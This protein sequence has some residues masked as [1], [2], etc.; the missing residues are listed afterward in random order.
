M[1]K[2][3]NIV[4]ISILTRAIYKFNVIPIK[5]PKSFFIEV[6]QTILKFIWNDKRPS[7]SQSKPDKEQS[8]KHHTPKFQT[9]LQSY[10]NQNSM[11]LA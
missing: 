9:I 1:I 8:W 2:T 7:S 3:I 5:I 6:E 11:V 10:N 4:K